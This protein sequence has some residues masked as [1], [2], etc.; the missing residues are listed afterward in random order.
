MM[1]IQSS[2]ADIA[3]QSES[4]KEAR[5]T[6][7][8][9]NSLVGKKF[10][11]VQ[12]A[13]TDGKLRRLSSYA[14]RGK[15]VLVDFWASWCGPCRREMPNVVAAYRK[16]HKKGFEIVGL[17]FDV[18]KSDWADAI[19]AWDMP[20]IHLS[21]LKGWESEAGRVYGV[22]GIPDNV[23]VNPEGIIVARGLR[24]PQLEEFLSKVIK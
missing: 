14:G 2:A 4:T 6:Q 3:G 17:S 24:G 22:S 13:D 11:D 23:L 9:Q 8:G 5:A 21:D 10:L 7:G 18:K 1:T 19:K 15:W 12:E 20:W 16:Y